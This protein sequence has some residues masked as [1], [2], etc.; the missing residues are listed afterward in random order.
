VRGQRGVKTAEAIVK[1]LKLKEISFLPGAAAFRLAPVRDISNTDN[2]GEPGLR[3]LNGQGEHAIII[4][5]EY[6]FQL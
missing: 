1:I 4:C 5:I 2:V 3:E 6:F